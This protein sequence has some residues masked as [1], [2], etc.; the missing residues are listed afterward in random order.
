MKRNVLVFED[1]CTLFIYIYLLG[2]VLVIEYNV[3]VLDIYARKY[4]CT[5]N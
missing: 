5:C 1:T 3:L 2:N 4:T